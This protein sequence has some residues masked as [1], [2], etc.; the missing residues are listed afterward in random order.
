MCGSKSTAVQYW[1][2]RRI[3]QVPTVCHH[4][5]CME[6]PFVP[7]IAHLLRINSS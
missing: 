4:D 1:A 7:Q 5:S 3:A 2:Y 6:E